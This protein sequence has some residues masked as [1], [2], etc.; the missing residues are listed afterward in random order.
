MREVTITAETR[1]D[2][3][4]GSAPSRRLRHQGRVPAVVYG[5]ETEPDAVTV[6]AHEMQNVLHRVGVNALINLT[7]GDTAQLTMARE[8][9]RHPV[10]GDLV[11]IDFV[12]IREDEAVQAEVA[13]HLM[14][15]PVGAKEGGVL[16]HVSFTVTVS[17]RPR[18][19]PESIEL[20]VSD[21]NVGEQKRV[22]DLPVPAGVELVGD[23]EQVVA[24]L[25]V[26]RVEEAAVAL[27]AEEAAELEGL[28]EEELEAL[29]VLADARVEEGEGEEGEQGE[30]ASDDGDSG[31]GEASSE[32]G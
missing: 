13:V 24:N 18:E 15:E 11:H 8:V 19:L 23:P 31:E 27:S 9:Q 17:A 21:L 10:R 2:A 22:S 29:Q 4:K 6:S 5:L 12:R 14:G 26:P 20:D 3:Q 25:V 30:G 7:F 28:S 1:D 16:E 32:E